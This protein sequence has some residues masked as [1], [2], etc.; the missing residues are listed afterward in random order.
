MD[1]RVDV[2]AP[3]APRASAPDHEPAH[4]PAPAPAPAPAQAPAH[5]LAHV[6]A[7]APPTAA[8]APAR[9]LIHAAPCAGTDGGRL[10]EALRRWRAWA[11]DMARQQPAGRALLQVADLQGRPLFFVNEGQ[12]PID[13]LLP[14]GT[15]HVI[16][17]RGTQHRRYTVALEPGATFH[18]RLRGAP[19]AG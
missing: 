11:A 18:L 4:E 13:V 12:G 14:P 5:V 17:D 3:H 2:Q 15:Y 19:A 1:A 8:N 7:H 6:P 10:A 16:V 9:L